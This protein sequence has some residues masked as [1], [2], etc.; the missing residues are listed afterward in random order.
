MKSFVMRARGHGLAA[1][2]LVAGCGGGGAVPAPASV[3]AP[4][5]ARRVMS[6]PPAG[7][8]N[9]SAM[10]YL[11]AGRREEFHAHLLNEAYLWYREI[12]VIDASLYSNIGSYFYALLTPALDASASARPV[13]FHR[14]RDRPRQPSPALP[15]PTACNGNRRQVG[16][17]P[18]SSKPVTARQPACAGRRTGGSDHPGTPDWYPNGRP[19]SASFTARR[20]ARHGQR[21]PEFGGLAGRPAAAGAQPGFQAGHK[22]AYLLFNAH[23][24]GAQDKLIAA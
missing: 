7:P 12:P 15:P 19:R 11:H 6:P 3:A 13:Q 8:D 9:S 1:A 17:V 5:S 10:R 23:T 24:R 4:R 14:D 21:H 20:P 16:S 18:P 2:L 22:V